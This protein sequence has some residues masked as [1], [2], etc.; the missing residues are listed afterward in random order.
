MC[1]ECV[2]DEET[3]EHVFFVC[4]CFVSARS[5]M[6]AVSGPGTTPD[7]LVRRMC[8]D[9]WNANL[10]WSCNVCGGSTTNTPV[11]AN[12]QS[13]GSRVAKLIEK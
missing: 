9:I 7:N 3:A 13:P 1:P 5:D 11:V 2:E 6:M 8:D 12:Y 4:P 10:S